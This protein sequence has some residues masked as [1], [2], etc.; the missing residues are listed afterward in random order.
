LFFFYTVEARFSTRLW[1]LLVAGR[2]LHASSVVPSQLQSL[3]TGYGLVAAVDKAVRVGVYPGAVQ[4]MT[5]VANNMKAAD[6]QREEKDRNEAN[7]ARSKGQPAPPPAATLDGTQLLQVITQPFRSAPLK[8]VLLTVP[9]GW[10]LLTHQWMPSFLARPARTS[11]IGAVYLCNIVPRPGRGVKQLQGGQILGE[12][13][14]PLVHAYSETTVLRNLEAC[15]E[16]PT[17]AA[18]VRKCKEYEA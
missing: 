1:C 4:L 8:A 13:E 14:N 18:G 2:L 10:G 16:C 15:F 3:G 12:P 7:L 11:S 6:R 17:K 9:A 5:E